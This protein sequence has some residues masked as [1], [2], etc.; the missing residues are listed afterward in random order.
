MNSPINIHTEKNNIELSPGKYYIDILGGWMVIE[1]RF[2]IKIENTATHEEVI[3]KYSK[4]PVQSIE[5]GQNAKRFYEIEI[6]KQGLYSI[7]FI[8]PT[9]IMVKR[10]NL[11]FISI[12]LKEIA[13]DKISIYIHKK[14]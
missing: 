3:V 13:N 14:F 2:R 12:F 6:T 10:W 5:F 1:N 7:D 4:W 11:P 9:D 8:N